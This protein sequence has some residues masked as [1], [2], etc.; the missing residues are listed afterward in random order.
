ALNVGTLSLSAVSTS[1]ASNIVASGAVSFAGTVNFVGN[2]AITAG[3][4]VTFTG[5]VNAGGPPTMTLPSGQSV[6]LAQG[7]WNEGANDL[8]IIGATVALMIGDNSGPTARLVMTGAAINMPGN[9]AVLVR[10]DGTIQAGADT[11]NLETLT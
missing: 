3:G 8:T 1:I 6:Q 7:T 9:G 4:G 10:N 2:R 5:D 11:T